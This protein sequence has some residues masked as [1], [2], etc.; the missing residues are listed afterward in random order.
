MDG[1]SAKVRDMVGE[2]LNRMI[3]DRRDSA[4]DE[5]WGDREVELG[6]DLLPNPASSCLMHFA[7]A[8][9]MERG[10]LDFGQ[11]PRLDPVQEPPKHR[12]TGIL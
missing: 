2:C 12:Q 7:D 1:G 8:V 10:V 5:I 4:T 11:D 9:D 6:P 3:G